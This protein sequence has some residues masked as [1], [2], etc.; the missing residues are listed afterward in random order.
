MIR[1]LNK[2]VLSSLC[3]S[4]MFWASRFVDSASILVTIP[5]S[6]KLSSK[7]AL[8]MPLLLSL[9]LVVASTCAALAE[10]GT[11]GILVSERSTLRIGSRIIDADF[12]EMTFTIERYQ[13]DWAW[14]RTNS[15]IRGWLPRKDIVPLDQA[16]A[17]FTQRI[18]SDPGNATHRHDRSTAYKLL[19]QHDAGIADVSV[20]IALAPREATYLNSRA[21]LFSDKGDYQHALTDYNAAIRLEPG[22]WFYW[23]NAGDAR[24][25]LKEYDKAIQNYS[26]AI[27]LQPQSPELYRSRGDCWVSKQ[28]FERAMCK[29][30]SKTA[31]LGG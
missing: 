18:T 21:L 16:V 28:D 19:G 7:R 4:L 31:A 2:A 30:R 20:A 25:S 3:R 26:R 9:A 6:T 17:Y 5:L 1:L 23:A 8:P 11:K 27:Q 13:G 22:S 29:R 10:S 15:G 24:L 14:I 12:R